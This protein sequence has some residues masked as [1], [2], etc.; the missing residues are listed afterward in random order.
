M[1]R[2]GHKHQLSLALNYCSGQLRTRASE[3]AAVA[4]QAANLA[5][6]FGDEQL[7]ADLLKQLSA[8]VA[9]AWHNCFDDQKRDVEAI[10][11]L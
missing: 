11:H 6:Q 7:K 9:K 3:G 10:K 4:L 2:I 1:L 8:G 5:Y